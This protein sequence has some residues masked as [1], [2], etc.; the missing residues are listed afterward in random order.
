MIR[1]KKVIRRQT[2][3]PSDIVS[4]AATPELRGEVARQMPPVDVSGACLF[5]I[6]GLVTKLRIRCWR[7][8]ERAPR[9]IVMPRSSLMRTSCAG[10]DT[11]K[12]AVLHTG[13]LREA[14]R[15]D[16]VVGLFFEPVRT[17]NRAVK[18]SPMHCSA[19]AAEIAVKMPKKA[20]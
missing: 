12:Q 13:Y 15:T 10:H 16:P 6:G 19:Q 4:P 1:S 18:V 3:T 14:G 17:K 20:G 5:P 7:D 9:P 2:P 11:R 8:D